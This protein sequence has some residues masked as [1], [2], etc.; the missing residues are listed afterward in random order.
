VPAPEAVTI[1][2]LALAAMEYHV[3]RSDV[4]RKHAV[5]SPA[6]DRAV[7][8]AI[9]AQLKGTSKVAKLYRLYALPEAANAT[10]PSALLRMFNSFDRPAVADFLK[11]LD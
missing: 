5:G 8:F 11:E 9:A 2:D 3:S 4:V 1:K 10:T 6:Y 7:D